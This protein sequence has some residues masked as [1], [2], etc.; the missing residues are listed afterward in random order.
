MAKKKAQPIK[1]AKGSDEEKLRDA[2]DQLRMAEI[3]VQDLEAQV[4]ELQDKIELPKL[5]KKLEG[6]YFKYN[7][8]YD[9][10]RRWWLYHKV[11]RVRGI[12]HI[13]VDSFETEANGK[14]NFQHGD[15]LHGTATLGSPITKMEYNAALKRFK[16]KLNNLNQ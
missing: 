15:E 3:E 4:D 12:H 16:D 14:S 7:N 8:G 10:E 9:K 2:K 1:V 6:K 11:I 13:I 5:K